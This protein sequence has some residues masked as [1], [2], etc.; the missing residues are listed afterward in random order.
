M[1]DKDRQVYVNVCGKEPFMI[2]F[3]R[4][5]E[6]VGEGVNGCIV[7]LLNRITSAVY[8]LEHD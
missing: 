6:Y 8:T 1:N 4:K 2:R 7:M 5:V 3:S